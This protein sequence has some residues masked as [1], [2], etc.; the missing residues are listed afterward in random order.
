VRNGRLYFGENT[1]RKTLTFSTV[2]SLALASGVT[3]AANEFNPD[4]S[5]IL[6]G[7]YTTYA[8]N[9][10]YELPGFLLGGEAGRGDKGFQL[11]HNELVLSANIDDMFYGK[12]T[13][14]IT[15]HDGETEVELEEAYIKTLSL[16]GGAAIKAGRFLSGIGYLNSQHPH[17]WDYA[18]APLV[19]RAMF[20]DTLLDDGVQFGWVA[21]TDVY[22]M[23]GAEL[24]RG[25]RFP[26]AGAANDGTGASALFLKLGS[27]IGVS[28]SWQL[29]LSHWRAEIEERASNG[30]A[31]DGS[32][33]EIPSYSG[34]TTV[35]GFDVVWKWAPNGN[36]RERNLKV[37]AEY[38]IRDEEG[39]INMVA[40]GTVAESSSYDGQQIGW[41][42]Q[43][44]YQFMPRWRV[45]LRYDQLRS[46]NSGDDKA[47]LAEAGLD[48]EGQHP[49][50]TT[51]ML[52]YA[53]SEY[54]RLRLQYAYDESY[55]DNDDIIT[56]QYVM[57]LGAHGAHQF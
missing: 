41:Y 16:G 12:M 36:A 44:V 42:T 31:H 21:P 24:T 8:N 7:R 20:G 10:E 9:S 26:A 23:L 46:D 34:D 40:D 15:D 11:G 43:A 39:M 3:K 38:F 19:Y 55:A 4:I 25:A 13:T 35:S 53:Y 37:Q 51:L 45:G 27:D 50:R 54:S 18:D 57:S 5:L 47:V 56:L 2:L 30:H 29:G 17:S 32:P 1:M 48:D 33:T 14:L 22:I 52:D 49:R 6:D 28:H